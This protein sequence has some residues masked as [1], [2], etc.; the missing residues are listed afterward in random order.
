MIDL[1]YCAKPIRAKGHDIVLFIYANE[2]ANNRFQPQGH[3]VAFKTDH[4]FRVDGKIDGS[5][6][7]FMKNYGLENIIAK[8]H[9]RGQ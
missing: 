7:T 4:A 5:M 6:R 2:G 9:G 8:K 1:E 3:K